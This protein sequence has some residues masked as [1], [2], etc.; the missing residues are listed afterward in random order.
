M[1]LD[2][3]MGRKNQVGLTL[4]PQAV[5]L[6][7]ELAQQTDSS[8]AAVIEAIAQAQLAL[9]ADTPQW[10]FHL[11]P[12]ADKTEV[13][14]WAEGAADAPTT[15]PEATPAEPVD[16]A[17]ND[18]VQI[19]SEVYESSADV[20]QLR[21]EK[22]ALQAQLDA[23]RSQIQQLQAQAAQPQPAAPST[24]PQETASPP[25]AAATASTVDVTGQLR[26]QVIS[27]KT[28]YADLSTAHQEQQSENQRLQAAL[29][30]SRSLANLGEAQL[31][32]WQYKTFSR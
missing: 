9:H 12:T 26:E 30:E 16:A 31:N 1:F 19:A 27:L 4:S 13:K 29:A 5:A 20:A 22:A 7:D 28:A 32:R 14:P 8:R 10:S 25:L 17:Q 18:H 11:V 6:L 3:V 24:P 15:A 21:Q 2:I 23:A